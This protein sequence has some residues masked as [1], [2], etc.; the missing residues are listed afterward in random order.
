MKFKHWTHLNN[1]SGCGFQHGLKLAH[2][3]YTLVSVTNRSLQS[4][5]PH[6]HFLSLQ[7]LPELFPSGL[8]MPTFLYIYL[9][10]TIKFSILLLLLLSLSRWKYYRVS[11]E[12]QRE[13]MSRQSTS[14][15]VH[16][17]KTLDNKYV[18]IMLSMIIWHLQ[19]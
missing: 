11:S 14:T 8:S 19:F 17:S 9:K 18:R 2:E 5:A 6:S 7:N 4:W 10:L 16:K 13:K 3:S 1:E 12:S 15:A